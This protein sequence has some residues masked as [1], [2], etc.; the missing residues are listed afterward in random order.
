MLFK[1]CVFRNLLLALGKVHIANMH[2]FFKID[3]II[4]EMWFVPFAGRSRSTCG[5][6]V[7]YGICA[8]FW[9]MSIVA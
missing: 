4:F 2:Q 3:T 9:Q 6:G 1:A 7:C 5:P 8:F